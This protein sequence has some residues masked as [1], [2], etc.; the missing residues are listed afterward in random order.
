MVNGERT[1]GSIIRRSGRRALS[2]L[3]GMA[4]AVGIASTVVVVDALPASAT[5][6]FTATASQR[7]PYNDGLVGVSADPSGVRMS[8]NVRMAMAGATPSGDVWFGVHDTASNDVNAW[9]GGWRQA[10]ID[11]LIRSVIIT[12]IPR[13]ACGHTLFV[14]ATDAVTGAASPAVYIT[15]NCGPMVAGNRLT[16]S[17]LGDGFTPGGA[18]HLA[19]YANGALLPVTFAI[20]VTA[21]PRSANVAGGVVR[22]RQTG[23]AC[24]R[25]EMLLGKDGTTG[26]IDKPLFA[27]I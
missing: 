14:A 18:V 23:P 19:A 11:G 10:D 1:R 24:T 25:S 22:V 4:L 13:S 3:A 7:M 6:P 2:L 12:G 15:D 5:G 27:C 20:N 21:T 26:A 17:I 9:Y 8:R 16:G